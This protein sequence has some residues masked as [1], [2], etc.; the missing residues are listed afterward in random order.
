MFKFAVVILLCAAVSYAHMPD[1]FEGCIRYRR[2]REEPSKCTLAPP[3][4]IK[5]ST[6]FVH[7]AH[8]ALKKGGIQPSSG[9]LNT[10]LRIT[11]GAR[12]NYRDLSK[13]V[14]IRVEFKTTPSSCVI[15]SNY[16]VDQCLPIAYKPN[17]LCQAKFRFYRDTSEIQ[18]AWCKPYMLTCRQARFRFCGPLKRDSARREPQT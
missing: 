12:Q 6:S 2:H 7:F 15:P 9:N 4:E 16:S 10:L 18:T 8:E 17:G 11:R 1:V 13:E 5:G 3:R 14:I